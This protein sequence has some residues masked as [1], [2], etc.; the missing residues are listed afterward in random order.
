MFSLNS[1]FE[2]IHL[3]KEGSAHK[4]IRRLRIRSYFDHTHTQTHTK[5]RICTTEI[6]LYIY[7][8][9]DFGL[10]FQASWIEISGSRV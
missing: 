5:T 3:K 4:T 1:L 2:M 9:A 8:L 6:V 7:S 10:V